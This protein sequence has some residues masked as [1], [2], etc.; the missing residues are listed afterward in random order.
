MSKKPVTPVEKEDFVHST[1]EALEC[2]IDESY[3]TA[4]T[5]VEYMSEELRE[6]LLG[7]LNAKNQDDGISVDLDFDGD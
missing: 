4:Y 5:L 3:C 1:I 2:V 7:A 6:T